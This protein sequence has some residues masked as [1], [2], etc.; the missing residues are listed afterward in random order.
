MVGTS[1]IVLRRARNS[2]MARRNIGIVR[3]IRG[4][5]RGRFGFFVIGVF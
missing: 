5:R 2:A 1:A 3:M 4:R